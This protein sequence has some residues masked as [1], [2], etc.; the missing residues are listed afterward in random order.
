[1]TL[2]ALK[3]GP[4]ETEA[5]APCFAYLG[6][7][8]DLALPPEMAERDAEGLRR[9]AERHGDGRELRCEPRL[10]RAGK[11][12]GFTAG[13]M[14]DWIRV[15]RAFIAYGIG[16]GP[17]GRFL[18]DKAPIAALLAAT[19]EFMRGAPWRWW[20]D[21]DALSVSVMGSEGRHYEGCLM[22]AGGQQ[23]GLALYEKAGAV[24]RIIERMD[25]D[26]FA[27]ARQEPC[28]SVTLNFEP[29]W[30]AKAADD[31]YGCKGLPLPMKLAGGQAVKLD[32]LS[33]TVLTAA[34]HA[35]AKLRPGNLM[36]TAEQAVPKGGRVR[37]TVEAAAPHRRPSWSASP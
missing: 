4:I 26:D 24:R 17:Y 32:A 22:G 33:L 34:L 10:A 9:L 19:G 16:L 1:M 29:A 20:S 31:A 11:K 14:P 18:E 5:E 7:A 30:A 2:Y 6:F 36:E 27:G 8:E 13:P 35:M 3:L 21:S 15:G 37:L 12:L 25:A 23:Y 28:L